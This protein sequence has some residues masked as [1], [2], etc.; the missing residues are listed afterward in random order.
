MPRSQVCNIDVHG[1]YNLEAFYRY[2][3]PFFVVSFI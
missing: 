2:Q 1:N 3:V